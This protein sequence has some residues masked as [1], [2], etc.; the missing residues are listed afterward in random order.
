LVNASRT[1]AASD[2]CCE[3]GLPG[4]VEDWQEKA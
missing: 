4:V 1:G 3:H 2:V